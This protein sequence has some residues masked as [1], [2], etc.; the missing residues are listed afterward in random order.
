[1]IIKEKKLTS[2]EIENLKTEVFIYPT[3]TIYGIGCDATNDKLVEK[4]REIKQRENKPFSIIAPSVQWILDN[5]NV[6]VR[7]IDKYLPGPYTLLL[8]KKQKNFLNSVSNNEFVG[9]RIPDCTFTKTLQNLNMPFVTTSVNLSGEEFANTIR[10][11]NKEILSK[12]NLI[13]DAGELS[14]KSSILVKD[15]EEIKR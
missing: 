3:D 2:E 10:E 15:G 13:I 6:N 8:E 4:I 11:I 5:F 14:G 7:L 9:I 12:V 1:M